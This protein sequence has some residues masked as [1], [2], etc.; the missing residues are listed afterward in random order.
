MDGRLNRISQQDSQTL[1]VHNGYNFQFLWHQSN[2][3]SLNRHL[4]LQHHT[5]LSMLLIHA[6]IS[7]CQ[8][9]P[10]RATVQETYGVVSGE[11]AKI[12]NAFVRSR[13]SR[14]WWKI[15][16]KWLSDVSSIQT[17]NSAVKKSSK[18]IF[19]WWRGPNIVN[20]GKLFTLSPL[21][22]QA[23]TLQ[24]VTAMIMWWCSLV[25]GGK[26]VGHCWMTLSCSLFTGSNTSSNTSTPPPQTAALL[27]WGGSWPT[28]PSKFQLVFLL[29]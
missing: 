1:Y 22:Q 20:P 25:L 5:T 16:A 24:T 17:I 10:T 21:S 28:F 9:G 4:Q 2:C 13:N 8:R 15:V 14:I 11:S 6:C 19:E 7:F 3:K 29:Q 26:Q 18:Y 27:Q 12:L 23:C